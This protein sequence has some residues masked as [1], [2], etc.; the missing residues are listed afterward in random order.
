VAVRVRHAQSQQRGE[1]PVHARFAGDMRLVDGGGEPSGVSV[2]RQRFAPGPL[3]RRF[4]QHAVDIE[5]GG[6]QWNWP[7]GPGW[8]GEAGG[9]FSLSCILGPAF[10][11][12]PLG[13]GSLGSSLGLIGPV[14]H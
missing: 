6:G 13:T 2:R 10:C 11:G 8:P 4:Q 7:I 5:D 12:R 1:R 3:M 9:H 14:V